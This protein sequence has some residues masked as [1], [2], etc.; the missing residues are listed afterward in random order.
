MIVELLWKLGFQM[1]GD[2][3]MFDCGIELGYNDFDGS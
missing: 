1:E 2:D 3:E